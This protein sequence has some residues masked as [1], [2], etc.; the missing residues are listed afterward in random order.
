LVWLLLLSSSSYY[1]NILLEYA[2]GVPEIPMSP[3]ISELKRMTKCIIFVAMEIFY[4]KTLEDGL[5]CI[6]HIVFESYSKRSHS[7]ANLD[8]KEKNL[9]ILN[10]FFI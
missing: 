1:E 10:L 2:L 3:G 9:Y 6:H 7:M 5:K 8:I 4:K